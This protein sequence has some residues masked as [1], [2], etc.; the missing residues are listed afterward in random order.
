MRKPVLPVEASGS[1]LT[2]SEGNVTSSKE[3][4]K[5]ENFEVVFQFLFTSVDVQVGSCH[6]FQHGRLFSLY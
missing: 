1:G 4:N 3:Q 6:L 2:F 5:A